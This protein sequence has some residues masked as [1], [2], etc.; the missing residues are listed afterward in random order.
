MALRTLRV[1]GAVLLSFWDY[2]SGGK[3][4]KDIRDRV[5]DKGL[6]LSEFEHD[7]CG[8]GAIVNIN[9]EASHE[10]V[11]DAL[12]I[13]ENLDHR[14]GKDGEGRIGFVFPLPLPEMTTD[15]EPTRHLLRS[16]LFSLER[17]SPTCLCPLRPTPLIRIKKR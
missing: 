1:S 16:Y 7:N 11:E 15:L 5:R 8:I 17:S 10:L 13:V 12:S 6:Y 3:D 9:G 4:M 2:I 14:A